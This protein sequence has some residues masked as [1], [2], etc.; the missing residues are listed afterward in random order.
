VCE[1]ETFLTGRRTAPSLRVIS[2]VREDIYWNTDQNDPTDSS[3]S[4]PTEIT[5]PPG[6][7]VMAAEGM[8]IDVHHDDSNDELLLDRKGWNWQW[9]GRWD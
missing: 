2:R 6:A 5:R 3:Q 9:D 8:D 1:Q 7:R 4:N